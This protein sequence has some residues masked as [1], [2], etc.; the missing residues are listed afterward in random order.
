MYFMYIYSTIYSGK[1][2]HGNKMLSDYMYKD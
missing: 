1:A 2:L